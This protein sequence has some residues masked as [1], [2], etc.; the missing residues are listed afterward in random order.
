MYSVTGKGA[1][2]IQKNIVYSTNFKK[3]LETILVRE[4]LGK[5]MFYFLMVNIQ[6]H[7]P[8]YHVSYPQV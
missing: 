8:G 5:Y 4:K 1:F 3:V 6:Y 7:C 2:F